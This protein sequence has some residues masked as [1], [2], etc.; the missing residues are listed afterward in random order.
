MCEGNLP[1]AITQMKH[2]QSGKDNQS[3]YKREQDLIFVLI[4]YVQDNV[5]E[6][7]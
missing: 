6:T 2:Q 3:G 1:L 5:C 7:D 4:L